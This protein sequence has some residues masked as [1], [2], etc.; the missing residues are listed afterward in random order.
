MTLNCK[1]GQLAMIVKP[2]AFHPCIAQRI[3]CPVKVSHLLTAT[4]LGAVI[5]EVVYGPEWALESAVHCPDGVPGCKGITHVP[6]S[7]LRP[8]DE[9]SELAEDEVAEVRMDELANLIEASFPSGAVRV[10]RA[11]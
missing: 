11:E 6:D 1:P 2:C 4:S 7:C 3:N 10:V 5:S 9:G 8:F